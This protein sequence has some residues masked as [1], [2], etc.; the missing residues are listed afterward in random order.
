M[1]AHFNL[2]LVTAEAPFQ[3][4]FITS[5]LENVSSLYMEDVE[6]ME[7]DLMMSVA[8]KKFVFYQVRIVQQAICT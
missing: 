5:L 7:I 4:T 3:D 8:V 2:K 6:G 1:C